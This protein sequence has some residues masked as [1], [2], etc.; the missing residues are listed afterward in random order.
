MA[1]PKT[2]GM[3][4]PA[5]L[6]V[7]GIRQLLARKRNRIRPRFA[8]IMNA[9]IDSIR[10]MASVKPGMRPKILG[11]RMMPV[12]TSAMTRGWRSLESGKCSSRMN[13]ITMPLGR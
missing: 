9:G 2:K 13:I 5:A 7:A 11:P 12:M 4:I 1:H 8:A 6:T 3:A 10:K